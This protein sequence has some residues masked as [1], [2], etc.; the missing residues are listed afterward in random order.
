M[1][2]VSVQ[3]ICTGCIVIDTTS[4]SSTIFNKHTIIIEL[5]KQWIIIVYV[6]TQV[7]NWTLM[8]W[9]NVKVCVRER[10]RE[11][12]KEM[13]ILTH[14]CYTVESNLINRNWWVLERD[15]Q[16]H[17][18]PKFHFIIDTRRRVW[19]ILSSSWFP[20]FQGSSIHVVYSVCLSLNDNEEEKRQ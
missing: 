19:F 6:N 20:Y 7:A 8:R 14:Q 4:G 12:G 10:E 18:C 9:V 13:M 11:R 5:F 15:N 3:L 1:H 17:L 16:T 2:I